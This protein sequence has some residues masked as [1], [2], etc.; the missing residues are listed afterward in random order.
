VALTFKSAATGAA[1]AL[2]WEVAFNA[3]LRRRISTAA[4]LALKDVG[5]EI[6]TKG[7]RAIAGAGFGKKWQGGYQVRTY[8]DK[9]P[10]I[11][12]AIYAYHKIPYAGIFETGGIIKGKGNPPLMW[13]PTKYAPVGL[14]NRLRKMTPARFIKYVGPLR[15]ARRRGNKAPLLI[16]KVGGKSVPLFVGISFTKQ[17]K[18]FNL[19]AVVTSAAGRFPLYYESQLKKT[20]ELRINF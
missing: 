17:R 6:D 1:D 11:D 18:R 13:L 5:D 9:K 19:G 15:S 14:G 8:P 20:D 7:K 3:S 2:D 12:A 16:G 4:W 10:S